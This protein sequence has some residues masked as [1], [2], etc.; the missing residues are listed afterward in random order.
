MPP[1]SVACWVFL[2]CFEV[3]QTCEKFS[4]TSQIKEYSLYCAGLWAYAR[5]KVGIYHMC[6]TYV[7]SK[8]VKYSLKLKSRK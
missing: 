6:I 1:G 3:L 7:A 4:D 2:S 8:E 5:E